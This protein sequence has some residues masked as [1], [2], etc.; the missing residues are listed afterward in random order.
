[1]K[2]IDGLRLL[3]SKDSEED[4]Y[5]M[6]KSFKK[7]PLGT[8]SQPTEQTIQRQNWNFHQAKTKGFKNLGGQ[9][10]ETDTD[11]VFKSKN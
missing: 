10:K 2:Y 6:R 7:D 9:G 3:L 5:D 4:A 1:M 8:K 11:Q